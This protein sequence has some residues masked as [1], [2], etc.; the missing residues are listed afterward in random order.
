MTE[1]EAFMNV[2]TTTTLSNLTEFTTAC[3]DE[4]PSTAAEG[5][6]VYFNST[7]VY[8]IYYGGQEMAAPFQPA[9][10]AAQYV[11]NEAI[12]DVAGGNPSY[13]VDW[14]Q[15]TPR[16]LNE[17]TVDIPVALLL[18]PAILYVLSVTIELQ[19]IIGPGTLGFCL[20]R[21]C[22]VCE[23]ISLIVAYYSGLRKDQSCKGCL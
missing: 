10:A 17:S 1:Q 14:I 9:L 5:V 12:V 7:N 4:M 19:F 6:C 18:V 20:S 16:L 11:M 23:K 3:Q 13:P 8:S 22:C 2:T 15:R 21:D